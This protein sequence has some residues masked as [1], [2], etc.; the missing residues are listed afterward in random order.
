MTIT[1]QR[2]DL[3]RIVQLVT[4]VTPTVTTMP[5]LNAV[6]VTYGASGL[7]AR[8]SNI[9]SFA[10]A[11]CE[12]T[13]EEF[14]A[15][16]VSASKLEHF[17]FNATDDAVTIEVGQQAVFTCGSSKVFLAIQ[18][19]REFPM[20]PEVKGQWVTLDAKQ[21]YDA[22]NR[23]LHAV[24]TKEDSHPGFCAVSHEL[25][26]SESALACYNGAQLAVKTLPISGNGSFL[27]PTAFIQPLKSVLSD[28]EGELSV[29]FGEN[30][31]KF[32]TDDWTMVGPLIDQKFVNWRRLN[33]DGMN[34][35]VV[36]KQD[37]VR[38]LKSCMPFGD[39]DGQ[40]KFTRILV[41]GTE[42][43]ITI[44]TS[45]AD[46]SLYTMPAQCAPFSFAIE[47]HRFLNA[48][49]SIAGDS[50]TIEFTDEPGRGVVI[51]EDNF[52]AAI[53]PLRK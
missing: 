46:A 49:N 2:K 8:G 47:A 45:G 12:A 50:V 23:I 20:M 28:V 15:F 18:N 27:V 32:S 9:R 35:I 48:V 33:F 3:L 30:H 52:T 29:T 26:D 14:E 11:S 31:V 4:T 5:S 22:L 24:H 51:R 37:L 17:L 13:G 39:L 10:E 38:G 34:K 40:I 53:M 6:L 7:S 43:L 42:N 16:G 1:T 41:T 36:T 44:E 21:Y 25:G 19:M